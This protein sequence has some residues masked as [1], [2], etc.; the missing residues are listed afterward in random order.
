MVAGLTV[1]VLVGLANDAVF[2]PAVG[3]LGGLA[4]GAAVGFLYGGGACMRHLVLRGLLVYNDAAPWRYVE[5]LD[6]ATSRLS[7]RRTGDCYQFV[8]GML[9][10]HVACMGT[11]DAQA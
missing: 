6:T 3:V 5:F 8:H 4:A 1:A 11:P 2:G 7:L 9:R 10:E